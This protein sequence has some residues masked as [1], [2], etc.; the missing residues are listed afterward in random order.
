MSFCSSP[1]V[2]FWTSLE[3]KVMLLN[4]VD[5]CESCSV[6]Y[7]PVLSVV[8]LCWPVLAHSLWKMPWK[9]SWARSSP[10]SHLTPRR[11]TAHRVQ[12]TKRS[13][14]VL[15]LPAPFNPYNQWH[16]FTTTCSLFLY[17]FLKFS[18]QTLLL[19]PS[20]SSFLLISFFFL[21]YYLFHWTFPLSKILF[22]F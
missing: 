7:G 21:S 19:C 12:L 9:S 17:L 11:L 22:S 18:C 14:L 5:L 10:L 3:H 16:F 1:N 8:A 4:S 15:F 13:L 6:C 20:P 2:F